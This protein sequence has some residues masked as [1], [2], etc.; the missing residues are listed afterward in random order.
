MTT[1]SPSSPSDRSGGARDQSGVEP[2]GSTA[3][4]ALVDGVLRVPAALPAEVDVLARRHL[5]DAVGVGLAASRVGPARRIVQVPRATGPCT[6]LGAAEGAGAADAALVNGTLV[7]SLEYDDTHTGSVMHGSAALAPAVLAAAQETDAPGDVVVRAFAVGWE[8]LVRIGLATPSGFQRVGFQGT[9]VAGTVAGAVAVGLVH[10]LDRDALLDA[11]GVAASFSAGNFTFLTRGATS[12]A[13][14][15]GIAAQG[16]VS[17]VAL[18]RGGITGGRSV[19]E[20]DR[21]FFGLYAHDGSAAGRL[22]DLACD[23]GSRWHLVDAAFK[24]L[25]CCHFLHPFAEAVAT[26]D[27]PADRIARLLCRVPAGQEEV[28]AVPWEAKQSPA[29]AGEARWSLPY[30]VALQAVRGAVTLDDFVGDPDPEVVAVAKRVEQERWEDSGYPAVFPA[31]IVAELTDGTVRTVRIDDVDGNAG[32][33]WD[34]ERVVAKFRDNCAR[35][36]AD[37]D[38]SRALVRGLLGTEVPDL[39]ALRRLAALPTPA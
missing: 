21:G 1:S 38:T 3:A 12:K 8:V 17:A 10:D 15:A 13:A 23:L 5:L 20:G 32:R 34:E 37:P 19:F 30:V 35:A 2:G 26:V 27:V 29:T 4:E 18:V 6:V 28:V 16:A 31:E 7:H 11:V 36:G 33:P 22:A 14:Q 39:T 25:P 9:S 24:G